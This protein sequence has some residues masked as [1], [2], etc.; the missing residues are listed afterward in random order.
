MYRMLR[1]IRPSADEVSIEL[2]C[3]EGGNRCHEL[4]YGDQAAIESLVS[5]E[6]VGRHLAC[7]EAA[8]R[9]TYVPV[10]QLLGDEVPDSTSS[11]GGLV[12]L[13]VTVYL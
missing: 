11:L 6:L 12:V 1:S 9:E 10:A 13:E 5:G 8:T 7:P 4:R 2:V 3:I